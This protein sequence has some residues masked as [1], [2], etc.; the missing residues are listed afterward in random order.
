VDGRDGRVV[1]SGIVVN[2]REKSETERVA[3]AV[4]G[5]GK[6]DNRLHLMA[7]T[8]KFTYAKT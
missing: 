6:V 2:D 1:L 8:R 3:S 5:V 4:A 7:I